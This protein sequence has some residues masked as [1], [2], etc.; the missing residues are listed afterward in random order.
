MMPKLIIVNGGNANTKVITQNNCYYFESRTQI[1]PD[2]S[3]KIWIN[4]DWYEIG[5]GDRNIDL[6]VKNETNKACTYYAIAENTFN[7]DC[8][9]LMLALPMNDFLDKEYRK[10][11][12]DYIVGNHNLSLKINNQPTKNIYINEAEV[13]MEGTAAVISNLSFFKDSLVAL[14]DIG[15]GTAN[16]AIFDD[17][18]I[19]RSSIT[20]LDLG[21][22]RLERNIIDR[23]NT[24]HKWNIQDYEIKYYFKDSTDPVIKKIVSEET[25]KHIYA[26][27]QALITKK[28]NVE[29]LKFFSTG[30]GSVS[31]STALKT[32]F[33]NIT[34]S[35]NAVYDNAKGL[36]LAAQDLFS[37]RKGM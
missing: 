22:A 1:N 12:L 27:K 21:M 19:I 4:D 8:I 3:K 18:N 7:T 34:I 28:W 20:T 23:L 9:N 31:C 36:W 26:I 11:Y 10:E 2:A 13:F 5:S 35:E 29:S 17:G 32:H 6:K 25:S 14:L 30:G 15:G 24:I 33:K 16:C 37:T